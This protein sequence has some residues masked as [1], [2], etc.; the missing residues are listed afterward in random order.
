MV[1]QRGS[2]G[3]CSRTQTAYGFDHLI[4]DL[5]HLATNSEHSGP[6]WCRTQKAVRAVR[7]RVCTD[8]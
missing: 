6:G 3:D 1:P 5:T 2:S 7:F 4:D 8:G